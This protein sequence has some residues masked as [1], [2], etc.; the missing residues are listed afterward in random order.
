MLYADRII[1]FYRDESSCIAAYNLNV[2]NIRKMTFKKDDKTVLTMYFL[3]EDN[4]SFPFRVKLNASKDLLE[5][6]QIMIE[7]YSS[8]FFV[9]FIIISEIIPIFDSTKIGT[10]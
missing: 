10:I 1:A 2:V 5:D 9:C 8:A 3:D 6:I 4:N 7:D